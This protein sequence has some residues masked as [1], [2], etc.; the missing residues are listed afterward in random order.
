M[1]ANPLLEVVNKRQVHEIGHREQ[2]GIKKIRREIIEYDQPK[3]GTRDGDKILADK[4][5]DP[6]TQVE[7]YRRE[8][9]KIEKQ[10]DQENDDL[11]AQIKRTKEKNEL[12][13]KVDEALQRKNDAAIENFERN[14][15]MRL[16]FLCPESEKDDHNDPRT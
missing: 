15:H 13:Q 10:K 8:L 11:E 1:E 2:E 9:A 14:Q 12:L 5:D 3:V 4:E 7:D 6:D 16:K